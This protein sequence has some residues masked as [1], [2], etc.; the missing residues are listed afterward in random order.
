MNQKNH[1]SLI[2]LLVVVAIIGIL[3][4]M[5]LPAL[6]KARKTAQAATCKNNIKQITL[7]VLSYAMDNNNYAPT[8]KKSNSGTDL[9][10]HRTLDSM[11]YMT[12]D[13][14]SSTSSFNCSN[15]LAI[16][17][18]WQNNYAMNF[19]LVRGDNT[20]SYSSSSTSYNYLSTLESSHSTDTMMIVDGY[21]NNRILQSSEINSNNIFE[22]SSD[23]KIARHNDKTNIAFLDGHIESMP[24]S[25]LLSKTGYQS[26][27][28]TP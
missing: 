27:F 24:G 17:E 2:E 25:T 8:D 19:R 18:N 26:D 13:I 5:L 23:S 10:W 4:S 11:S 7:A 22:L 15:G 6:G 12:Y 20:G 9:Q 14:N 21:N 16:S 1:F 3:A 28:W